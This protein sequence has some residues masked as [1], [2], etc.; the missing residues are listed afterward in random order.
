MAGNT[1][2]TKDD[3]KKLENFLFQCLS[4]GVG[5]ERIDNLAQTWIEKGGKVNV[6]KN[7]NSDSPFGIM[8]A[9]NGMLLSIIAIPLIFQ[10]AAKYNMDG[11]LAIALYL[12]SVPVFNAIITTLECG[13][14][15]MYKHISDKSY[16]SA[17]VEGMAD[18]YNVK[19]FEEVQTRCQELESTVQDSDKL[20]N[21]ILDNQENANRLYP[22]LPSSD[23]QLTQF[24]LVKKCD[25]IGV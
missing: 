10:L 18:A 13:I 9:I 7:S 17:Y 19:C 8:A 11:G 23:A 21:K 12:I 16:A 25:L 2:L 6:I 3:K 14:Y 1:I 5:K 15:L 24:V 4:H 20:I 22:N